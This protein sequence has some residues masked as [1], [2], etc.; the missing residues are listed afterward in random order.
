MLLVKYIWFIEVSNEALLNIILEKLV[1]KPWAE[2]KA[3]QL[4]FPMYNYH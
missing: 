2:V 3:S 4:N 1:L